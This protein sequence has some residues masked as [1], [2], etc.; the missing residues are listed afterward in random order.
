MIANHALLQI[1]SERIQFWRDQLQSAYRSGDRQFAAECTRHL[2]EYIALT[3][4]ASRQGDT[5]SDAAGKLQTTATEN[6]CQ[7]K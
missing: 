2:E 7:I 1:V 3:A 6:G 5:L 4:L